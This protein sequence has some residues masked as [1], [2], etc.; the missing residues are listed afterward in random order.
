MANKVKFVKVSIAKVEQDLAIAKA[1]GNE[2]VYKDLLKFVSLFEI[3]ID[4]IVVEEQTKLFIG[5][6][7]SVKMT[8]KKK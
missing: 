7:A 2:E 4:M 6:L 5:L 3:P 1:T 8:D